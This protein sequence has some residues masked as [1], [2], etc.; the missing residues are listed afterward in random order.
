MCGS[1]GEVNEGD[2]GNAG[3]FYKLGVIQHVRG[4]VVTMNPNCI[5]SRASDRGLIQGE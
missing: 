4:V 2:S 1:V 3:V 5:V